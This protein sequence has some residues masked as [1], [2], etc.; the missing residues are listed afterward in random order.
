[1]T[2]GQT[3]LCISCLNANRYRS[4]LQDVIGMFVSTL[5]YRMQLD[6]YWSFDELVK[7][8]REKCLTILEHSHYP[9]QHILADHHLN[10][11]NASFLETMFDF[12]TTSD[13]EDDLYLSD[14]NLKQ[15]FLGESYN[16]A[17]FDFSLTFIHKPT[18]TNGRL[19]C[20]FECSR[21]LFNSNSLETIA[22]RFE[23]LEQ[24]F[25]YFAGGSGRNSTE[26]ISKT[27]S[28]C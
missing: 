8:V 9:L 2:H 17:K 4:E 23:Y 26:S 10:Q 18:A 7:H 27:A 11:S 12:V 20:Y 3:D 13:V 14:S 1:M 6:S 25:Y 5:P 19:S 16:V 28:H 15:V 21:D 22:R 24:V